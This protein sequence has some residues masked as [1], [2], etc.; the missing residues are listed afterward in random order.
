MA[1]LD[2]SFTYLAVLGYNVIR[3]RDAVFAPLKLLGR[4]N[5]DFLILGSLNQLVTSSLSPLSAVTEDQPAGDE[6]Y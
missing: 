4:Q 1:R 3:H 5:S 2:R 6:N